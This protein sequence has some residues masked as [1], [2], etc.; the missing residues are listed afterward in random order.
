MS[1]SVDQTW[2][3]RF[4]NQLLLTY[5]QMMPL[6]RGII[7]PSM[8]HMDVHAAI[9]HHERMGGLM[10]NDT[11]APFGP[12]V[13]LNPAHSKR[14]CTLVSSDAPVLVSDEHTLRAMVN[15]QNAYT[16]T[17]AAA[18]TRRE[19]KHII[20]AILGNAT[21]AAV[22]SGTGI[23]SYTSLALPSARRL[24]IG[25]STAWALADIIGAGEKLSKSGVPAG[26]NER[27]TLYSPGQERDIMNIAQASS[28][29]FTRHRV[30]DAGT[31]NGIQWEG[32]TWRM[33]PDFVDIDGST[34]VGR[35]L[36]LGSAGAGSRVVIHFHRSAIG[37]SVGRPNGPPSISIRHDLG[38]EPVQVRQAMMMAAVRVFEGGVVTNDVKE[39]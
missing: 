26:A 22:G 3:Y 9:D 17:I 33:V 36:P 38:S 20:D 19:D 2:V 18:L 15:P 4:H 7:D 11:I 6:V 23:I 32:F 14:A 29:D 21:V 34:V 24:N 39:N 35:M 30:H 12:M 27:F 8:V 10:A 13:P 25:G 31:V 37:V 1:V 5:Q 16:R 28:S